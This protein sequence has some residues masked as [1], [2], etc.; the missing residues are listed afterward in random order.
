MFQIRIPASF[1]APYW[2]WRHDCSFGSDSLSTLWHLKL[3]S[4]ISCGRDILYKNYAFG[5]IVCPQRMKVTWMTRQF[6]TRWFSQVFRCPASQYLT[7]HA[8]EAPLWQDW[9]WK[10]QV[11]AGISENVLKS[12]CP[13]GPIVH[14][15]QL[16]LKTLCNQ[17]P[18]HGSFPF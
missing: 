2:T 1:S 15:Y 4:H 5:L 6:L 16:Y 12:C 9:V 14:W 11:R 17:L 3:P 8:L 18:P 13:C 7:A 10:L